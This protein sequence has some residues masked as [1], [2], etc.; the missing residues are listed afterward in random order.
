LRRHNSWETIKKTLD[1]VANSACIRSLEG[2]FDPTLYCELPEVIEHIR[3]FLIVWTFGPDI[4]VDDQLN[5]FMV[6][7]VTKGNL[8]RRDLSRCSGGIITVDD[9]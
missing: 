9:K 3:G 4:L 2:V 7:N 6:V 8:Q 5:E 1:I